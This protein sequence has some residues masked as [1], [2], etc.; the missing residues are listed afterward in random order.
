[1]ALA[2]GLA[3]QSLGCFTACA[4]PL[5]GSPGFYPWKVAWVLEALYAICS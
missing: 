5:L 2:R 3:A 1:L 4:P